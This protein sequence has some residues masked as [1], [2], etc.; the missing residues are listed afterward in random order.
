MITKNLFVC[1]FQCSLPNL[2]ENAP[3]FLFVTVLFRKQTQRLYL[4]NK[5]KGYKAVW[6]RYRELKIPLVYFKVQIP[7]LSDSSRSKSFEFHF[8]IFP[9][10]SVHWSLWCRCHSIT[11][12]VASQDA[13]CQMWL[14]THTESL[15]EM[16]S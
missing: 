13:I 2:K 10:R 5:S 9:V 11:P 6:M 3:V 4:D 14:H 16:R 15:S 12:F 8:L 1:K 7:S